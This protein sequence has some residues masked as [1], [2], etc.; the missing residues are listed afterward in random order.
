MHPILRTAA[1]LLVVSAL[2]APRLRAQVVSQPVLSAEGVRKA[3][4]AAEAEAHRN[5]WNVSIAVVDP[6]GTLLGFAKMDEASAASVDV[7]QAK[8]RSAG[9]FR[10][11][12][13]VFEDGV[14]GGRAAIMSLPGVVAVEGG[15]PLLVDGKVVAAVGVSGATSPQDGQVAAAGVVG[16]GGTVPPPPAR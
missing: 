14:A 16:A 4:A 15:V 5:G 13:K 12:T 11:A 1:L 6:A 2:A 10:R 9:R 3:L 8:A 7:S